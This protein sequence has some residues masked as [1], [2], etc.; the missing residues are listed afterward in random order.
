MRNGVMVFDLR[1]E[2]CLSIIVRSSLTQEN[3]CIIKAH[4]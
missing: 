2:I 1:G 4:D 3:I